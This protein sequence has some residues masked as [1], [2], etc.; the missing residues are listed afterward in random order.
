MTVPEIITDARSQYNEA[1]LLMDGA[2]ERIILDNPGCKIDVV[3]HTLSCNNARDIMEVKLSLR[4]L[5]RLGLI[6]NG[7]GSGT[8]MGWSHWTTLK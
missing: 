5:K 7:S 8:K 6:H 1:I 4:R 2:V 3:R